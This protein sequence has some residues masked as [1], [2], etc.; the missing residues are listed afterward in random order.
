[1]DG[2]DW[3]ADQIAALYDLLSLQDRPTS[4]TA[5]GEQVR[6]SVPDIMR[7][8]RESLGEEGVKRLEKDGVKIPSPLPLL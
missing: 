1:M 6:K 2:T 4:P 7:M 5:G 8:V 3:Q